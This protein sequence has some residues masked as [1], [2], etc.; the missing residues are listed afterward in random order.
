MIPVN[1]QV[2]AE[3][4]VWRVRGTARTAGADYATDCD[5][6]GQKTERLDPGSV[7]GVKTA[8]ENEEVFIC[9]CTEGG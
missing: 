1:V 7:A 3:T 6:K 2:H 4:G 8:K 5:R 9:S